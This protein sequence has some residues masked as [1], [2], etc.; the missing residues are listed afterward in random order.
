M[1]ARHPS[2]DPNFPLWS[3]TTSMVIPPKWPRKRLWTPG[4]GHKLSRLSKAVCSHSCAENQIPSNR[5]CYS[6]HCSCWR[7]EVRF[8]TMWFPNDSPQLPSSTLI[9][10]EECFRVRHSG[11]LAK[12][13]GQPASPV[14]RVYDQVNVIGKTPPCSSVPHCGGQV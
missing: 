8:K 6:I 2:F 4:S 14:G 1:G 12:V 11:P 7:F 13:M 10:Q 5:R 9:P 3:Q